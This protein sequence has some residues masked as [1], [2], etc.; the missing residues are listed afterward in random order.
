MLVRAPGKRR[1]VPN[2]TGAFSLA[3]CVR[4]GVVFQS[5]YWARSHLRGN[6]RKVCPLDSDDRRLGRGEAEA[7]ASPLAAA[8]VVPDEPVLA[9]MEHWRYCPLASSEKQGAWDGEK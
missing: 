1:G 3:A 7:H 2:L 4:R 8:R 9:L 5:P 6:A